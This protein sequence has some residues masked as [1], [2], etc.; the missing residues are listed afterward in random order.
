MTD[1]DKE[2]ERARGVYT[3]RAG[4]HSLS[5]LYAPF[6]PAA[7]FTV[8]DREWIMADLLRRSGLWSLADL[9]IL[10]V[11]CGTGGE[12]RRMTTMGADPTRL[13]GLDLMEPRIVEARKVLT[14]AKFVVGSGHE[15]P[16]PDASFDV[17]TQFVVFSSVVHPGVREA[18]AHEMVRVLR[19]NGRIIWYDIK[20]LKPT[21]DL[22]PIPLTEVKRIFAGCTVQARPATLA[23]RPAHVLAPRSRVAAVLAAK[24]PRQKSHYVALIRKIGAE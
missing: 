3:A 23:W 6:A 17:V 10:D 1:F 5:R 22:V 15:L 2:L 20:S 11:G 16:F 18:I 14:A 24:L 12:M 4:N 7:L 13:T 19:P 21:P 8:Q 9:D